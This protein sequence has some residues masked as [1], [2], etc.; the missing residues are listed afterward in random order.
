MKK[1]VSFVKEAGVRF[2]IFLKGF[3]PCGIFQTCFLSISDSFSSELAQCI[4]QVLKILLNVDIM[5]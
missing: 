2:S 3:G 4:S 1:L 5:Q